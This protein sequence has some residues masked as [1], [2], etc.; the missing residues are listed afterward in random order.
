MDKF[1]LGQFAALIKRELLE[2]RNLFIG[3]PVLLAVLLSAAIVWVLNFG[4]KEVL[5]AAL[6]RLGS[7]TEG[8]AGADLAPL[9]MPVSIPWVIALYVCILAYLVNTLY[10]DRRDGSV[11]FWQSMPVSNLKTVLSKVLTGCFIAP[12]LTVAVLFV[13]MLVFAFA[14]VIFA[15][16]NDVATVGLGQLLVAIIDSMWLVYLTMIM[17]SLWLLPT[18][19][20]L[21]VFSAFAKGQ[22]LMW[23]IGTFVL[24][25]MLEGFIFDSQY[26]ANWA[27][28][29]S[30]FYRYLVLEPADFIERLFTYDTFFGIVLGA[31]VITGATY[32]RRFTD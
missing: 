19:G 27:E 10:Q 21:L 5:L 17:A 16:I 23:A 3:G 12:L 20:W 25:V 1:A 7:I 6:R 11:L 15:A 13:W 32:M 18:I 8:V 28:S 2:H 14:I 22:P 9:L 24:I 30:G 31:L 26:L 4:S 29:R